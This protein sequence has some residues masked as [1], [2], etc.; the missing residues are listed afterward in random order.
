M[1]FILRTIAIFVAVG[2]AVWLIP[3]IDIVGTGSSW[4][5]IAVMALIIALL[6]MTIK[7][8][9]QL[10]GLPITVLSLGVFY[11]VINTI[12]LYVAASMGNALFGAEALSN[13]LGQGIDF[14]LNGTEKVPLL[15]LVG[16][17]DGVHEA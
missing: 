4:G 12:L 2:V 16:S 17:Q 11:L 14:G 15:V 13:V 5:S 10:I 8:F 9:L 6:N 3:G 7:P 1:Q